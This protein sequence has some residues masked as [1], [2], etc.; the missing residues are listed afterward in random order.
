MGLLSRAAEA[1]A[2]EPNVKNAVGKIDSGTGETEI[3][4]AAWTAL[5]EEEQTYSLDDMGKALGERIKRLPLRKSTPYT[6]LS[7]LK[8]YSN[9]QSGVC[10]LLNDG[11]Y[12]SFTSVGF[13]IEKISIPREKIWSEENANVSFFKL[14]PEKN[15]EIKDTAESPEYWVFPLNHEKPD[16]ESPH[17]WEGI[18]VLGVQDSAEKNSPFDPEAMAA[19]IPEIVDKILIRMEQD[20]PMEQDVPMEQDA[21][22]KEGAD[23]AGGEHPIEVHTIEIQADDD[24]DNK[25]LTPEDRITQFYQIY[26]DMNYIVLEIPVSSNGEGTDL[27]F[28]KVSDM[29]GMA[30]TTVLL[31][32]GRPLILL[33]KALDR[34]LIAHRISKS[35]N[36]THLVSSSANDP[37]IIIDQIKSLA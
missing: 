26:S 24:Q 27:F 9:F 2:W 34:E 33:P 16:P 8:A 31:S 6:A 29:V 22:L 4:A 18:M 28:K 23:N 15:I 13:G 25:D 17:P 5:Q 19:I 1:T 21:P 36:T 12:A 32:S 10:L 11:I 30:G 20:A 7:L 37:Q 14:D 3:L 35:L